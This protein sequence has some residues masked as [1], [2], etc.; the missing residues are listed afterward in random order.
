MGT[1][2]QVFET[3]DHQS[4][5]GFGDFEKNESIENYEQFRR[6]LSSSERTHNANQ[7]KSSSGQP[8]SSDPPVRWNDFPPSQRIYFE[9][10]NPLIS[11][12]IP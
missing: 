9:G 11:N 1:W 10:Q 7:N 3:A 2:K 8:Q 5:Q 6:S 4:P 12:D